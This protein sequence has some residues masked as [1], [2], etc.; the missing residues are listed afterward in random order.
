MGVSNTE[1]TSDIQWNV[2]LDPKLF[3]TTPPEG[4][5][6]VTPKPLALDEQVRQI[7]DA[8]RIYAEASG[9]HY[10]RDSQ[11][12]GLKA[13]YERCKILGIRWQHET[14]DELKVE[15]KVIAGYDLISHLQAYN[16]G[17]G[18][19]GKTVGPKDKDKVLL[20]W[21]LDDGRYEVIFGDLRAEIVTAERL[22]ALERK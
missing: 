10:S 2:D 22:R 8:L 18:Y 21:K 5:K 3:D 13:A 1:I 4:Y 9:G 19:Y 16:P 11:A 7:T 6:D 12:D 15:K 14:E 20:R 17:A